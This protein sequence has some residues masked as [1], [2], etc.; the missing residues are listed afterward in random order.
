MYNIYIYIYIY[1]LGGL[2]VVPPRKLVLQLHLYGYKKASDFSPG[3]TG[4]GTGPGNGLGAVSAYISHDG[5]ELLLH[6]HLIKVPTTT[7][8]FVLEID[9][10]PVAC[11]K[12]HEH[13]V[14]E[15][16][17][18]VPVKERREGSRAIHL[19]CEPH[20]APGSIGA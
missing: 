15:D 1:T 3:G 2:P 8:E 16:H 19:A 10:T 11:T 12:A 9:V 6:G 14:D 18:H 17:D 20:D 4:S 7:A 13:M 5:L